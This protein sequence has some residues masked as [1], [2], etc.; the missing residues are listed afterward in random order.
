[1]V[2]TLGGK[3]G[4]LAGIKCVCFIGGGG[5]EGGWGGGGERERWG[6]K[7]RRTEAVTGK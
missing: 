3:G 7:A 2:K 1:M 4:A 5:G 6:V